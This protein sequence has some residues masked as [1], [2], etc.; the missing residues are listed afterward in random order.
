MKRCISGI[1]LVEL[2]ATLAVLAIVLAIGV[3]SF[4]HF[5]QSQRLSTATNELFSAIHL[6]RSE[7]IQRGVKVDLIPAS[8][9]DWDKGWIIFVDEDGDQVL[10]DNEHVVFKHGP[11]PNGIH[12]TSSFS[13]NVPLDIAYDGTGRTRSRT[14]GPQF[15][16]FLLQSGTQFRRKISI[17]MLGRG[18][19]CNPDADTDC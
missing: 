15:G 10:D 16:N 9:M 13:V 14:G 7:A 8:G 11:V 12:I 18:R 19:V 2:L 17:S 5:I 3:P 1:S 4:Q 6:V